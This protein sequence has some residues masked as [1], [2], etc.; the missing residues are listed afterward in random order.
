MDN[1]VS[2]TRYMICLMAAIL[3]I[4][5]GAKAVMSATANAAEVKNDTIKVV[6]DDSSLNV[7]SSDDSS[8]NIEEDEIIIYDEDAWDGI[9]NFPDEDGH[10]RYYMDDLAEG[11]GTLTMIYKYDDKTPVSG[12]EISIYRIADLT[13]T[14]GNAVYE[15]LDGYDDFEYAGVSVDA[16]N[17][18]AESQSMMAKEKKA[19]AVAITDKDGTVVFEDLEYGMYLVLETNRT[20]VALDYYDFK[21]FCINVP[22]PDVDEKIYQG[23]WIY[24]VE[25][26]PK[27]EIVEVPEVPTT[28]STPDKPPVEPPPK[29]GGA[30]EI[31]DS[32][33]SIYAI[34][35][36]MFALIAIF[37]FLLNRRSTNEAED[38]V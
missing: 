7:D 31:V 23:H 24:D 5:T 26:E 35:S 34:A 30:G 29:T 17:K 33:T 16:L 22:F 6:V 2:K 20:G 9:T 3:S 4:T 28:P 15:T 13:V 37:A 14:N 12:A 38:E 18:Y 19:D 10:L 21:P 1:N 11:K 8:G 32:T 27:T 36:V 25:V